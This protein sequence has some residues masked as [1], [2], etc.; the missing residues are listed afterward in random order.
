MK[1]LSE[2]NMQF[3]RKIDRLGKVAGM[4]SDET[5]VGFAHLGSERAV[6]NH[7]M[8]LISDGFNHPHKCIDHTGQ[9]SDCRHF[10]VNYEDIRHMPLPLRNKIIW[11]QS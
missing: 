6:L 5:I 7:S 9:V 10:T 2:T 8:K 3:F 4:I 1:T 11:L